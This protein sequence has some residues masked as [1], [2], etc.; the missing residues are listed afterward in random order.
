MAAHGALLGAGSALP[1]LRVLISRSS[2]K[3]NRGRA[4]LYA[5]RRRLLGAPLEPP[6][7][8]TPFFLLLGSETTPRQGRFS[9]QREAPRRTS[10]PLLRS[11]AEVSPTIRSPCLPR[12]SSAPPSAVRLVAVQPVPAPA[13][14]PRAAR[15]LCSAH[16]ES[17]ARQVWCTAVALAR[18]HATVGVPSA[19]GRI[20]RRGTLG[21]RG[22]GD[23]RR[24]VV[25]C[26]SR[27]CG[28]GTRT[29]TT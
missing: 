11:H 26:D 5:E 3:K 15:S 14:R 25:A 13:P 6:A 7:T 20:V 18:H 12:R 23:R 8:Q 1:H 28:A 29:P 24:L 10:L 19:S 17:R 16:V 27:G 9:F 21:T 2:R 4:V 22:I